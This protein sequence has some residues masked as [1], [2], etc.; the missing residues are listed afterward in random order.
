[1]RKTF[2]EDQSKNVKFDWKKYAY[3]GVTRVIYH[4]SEN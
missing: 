3:D 4:L 1:M 2:I